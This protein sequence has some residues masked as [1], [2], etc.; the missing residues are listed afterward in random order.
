MLIFQKLI[1]F[2]ALAYE[3]LNQ[4]EESIAEL[5][6]LLQEAEFNPEAFVADESL[7]PERDRD[8]QKVERMKKVWG[9][10]KKKTGN[11]LANKYFEDGEY[12]NAYRIYSGAKTCG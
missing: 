12:F 7:K 1:I 2:L 5:L 3:H 8:S 4:D 9:F 11:Y 10:W 6:N